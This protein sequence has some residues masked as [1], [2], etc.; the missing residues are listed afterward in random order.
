[1]TELKFIVSENIMQLTFEGY[2][3]EPNIVNESSIESE[4][5]T[6]DE[7]MALFNQRNY[8][9][10]DSQEVRSTIVP[11]STDSVYM[12]ST[13][14]NEDREYFEQGIQKQHQLTL[15]EIV[16]GQGN[17]LD[18]AL[19]GKL[20]KKVIYDHSENFSNVYNTDNELIHP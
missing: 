8:G 1:M 18:D 11:I 20:W 10:V 5:F 15:E 9:F 4:A 14:D 13:S 2:S 3:D 7:L 17:V 6:K 16:D 19:A 12:N